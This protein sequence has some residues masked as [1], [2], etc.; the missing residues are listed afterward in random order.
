M[1]LTMTAQYDRDEPA[2]IEPPDGPADE[3]ILWFARLSA[4]DMTEQEHDAFRSWRGSPV[5]EKAFKDICALWDKPEL[6]EAAGTLIKRGSYTTSQA[7][8][9]PRWSRTFAAAAVVLLVMTAVAYQFDIPLRFQADHLTATGELQTVVLAD[10]STVTLNTNSAIASGYR[11]DSRRI[12][13]L[14]GEALFKVQPDAGRPFLVEHEGIVARAVGTS[15]VVR[16]YGNA[17]HVSV[18]EGVVSVESPTKSTATVTAG[19]RAIVGSDGAIVVEAID[20]DI[21][22]AWL[23]GRLVFE[24][25]PFAR[26]LEEVSR[27][28]AGYVGIWNPSLATLSV[29]GTYNLS[30]PDHI[31][32][33]L[34]KTL[35]VEMTRLTDRFVVFR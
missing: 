9:R 10:Q 32:T 3:A 23:H 7:P 18:I 29:S 30:N 20:P 31:L 13:L 26:V 6:M 14:K 11:A 5:H 15:F 1:S 12:R 33:T 21:A 22:L 4:G 24:D 27:Y 19:R 17:A 16:E 8:S 2:P 35:P 25:A 28:H 34:A